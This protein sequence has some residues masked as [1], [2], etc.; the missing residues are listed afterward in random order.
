MDE[1]DPEDAE[2]SRYLVCSA[3]LACHTLWYDNTNSDA[4]FSL[5]R[6]IVHLRPDAGNGFP[7]RLP[8]LFLFAQLHGTP[9]DYLLRVRLTQIEVTDE[10]EEVL[11]EHRQYGPWEIELPGDNYVE[12]FGL[13]LRNVFIPEAGIYEFQLWADGFDAPLAVER[14]QARE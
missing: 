1:N 7:L 12:C 11:T 14:F 10:G 8:R 3:L 4:G 2:R 13:E 6:L 5:G 9:D